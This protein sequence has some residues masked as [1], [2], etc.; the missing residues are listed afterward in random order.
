MATVYFRGGVYKIIVLDGNDGFISESGLASD[1]KNI[2]SA[3]VYAQVDFHFL[4]TYQGR[5]LGYS[6]AIP[7]YSKLI[8]EVKA[9]RVENNTEDRRRFM[10]ELRPLLTRASQE[11]S[12]AL[13]IFNSAKS[14]FTRKMGVEVKKTPDADLSNLGR[15][16][17]T[18]VKTETEGSLRSK[19]FRLGKAT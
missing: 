14:N 5:N 10:N 2:N 3:R 18:R 8:G 7:E 1:Y 12:A 15:Q 9:H 4:L 16:V 11:A 6:G 17:W 19:G 13:K